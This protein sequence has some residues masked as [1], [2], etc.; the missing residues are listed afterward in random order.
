V[1]KILYVIQDGATTRPRKQEILDIDDTF[2]AAH[3]AQQ[4]AFWNAHHDD[5][6]RLA[7]SG[8]IPHPV[9]HSAVFDHQ[10]FG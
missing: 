4:L 3:G 2:C 5:E 10:S 8:S 9:S 6:T 1:R 7:A